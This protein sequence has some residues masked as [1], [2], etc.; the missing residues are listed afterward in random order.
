MLTTYIPGMDY[1]FW[2]RGPD[3]YPC[4]F[5]TAGTG[6][7]TQNS[8]SHGLPDVNVHPCIHVH[9]DDRGLPIL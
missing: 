2:P 8:R 3:C 5:Y 4:K 1:I 7:F 6:I 9:T